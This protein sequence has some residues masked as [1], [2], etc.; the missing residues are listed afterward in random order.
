MKRL[1]EFQ[2]EQLYGLTGRGF[3]IARALKQQSVKST[4]NID[5]ETN[6]EPEYTSVEDNDSDVSYAIELDRESSFHQRRSSWRKSHEGFVASLNE[7]EKLYG[8]IKAASLTRR[9]PASRTG[10]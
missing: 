6:N 2:G 7:M 4:T 8:E 9:T 1:V 3:K 5:D 10:Y